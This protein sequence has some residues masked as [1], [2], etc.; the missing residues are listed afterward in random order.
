MALSLETNAE[1]RRLA[2]V[3]G[4]VVIDAPEIETDGL[5]GLVRRLRA[6]IDIVVVLFL[7][8]DAQPCAA[9]GIGN[10]RGPADSNRTTDRASI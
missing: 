8:C 9:H 7:N 3:R 1:L 5:G 2:R 4:P 6:L 10:D